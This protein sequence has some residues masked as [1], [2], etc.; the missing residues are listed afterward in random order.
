MTQTTLKAHA[1]VTFGRFNVC[2]KAHLHAFS[3][4]LKKFESLDV[5]VIDD[6]LDENASVP[7]AEHTPFY[8]QADA[9]QA[10]TTFQLSERLELMRLSTTDLASRYPLQVCTIRRPEY[11]ILEFNERFPK[12]KYQLVF[13][14]ASNNDS[15]SFESIRNEYLPRILDRTQ[16]T[17]DVEFIQHVADIRKAAAIDPLV[18]RSIMVPSAYGYFVSIHGPE[19]I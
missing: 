14:S 8:V 18:W 9:Q 15:Q 1:A 5:C 7:K 10:K 13:S 19:R 2:T 11:Y 16:D 3:N 6:F 17:V 4:F 12:S